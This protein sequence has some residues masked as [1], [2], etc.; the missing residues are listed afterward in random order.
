MTSLKIA[1]WNLDGLSPNKDHV[2]ILLHTHNID[3]LLVSETHF[4]ASSCVKIKNYQIYG[5]N[6]PD[7]TAHAGSAVIVRTNIRHSEQRQ[8]KKPHIQAATITVEDR[9]GTFNVTAVY[10][11]P[12]HKITQEQYDEL[13]H[14]L[15]PRFIVGGDWNAKNIHWGSRLTNTRGRALMKS[16]DKNKLTAISTPEPTNW[17]SDPNRLPDVIDFFIAK[18]LPRLYY[19]IETCLDANTNHVPVILTIG[20][21][22]VNITR[23]TR[24]YNRR[25]DWFSFQ[26]LVH[27]KLDLKTD[28]KSE[29]DIDKAAK[30]FTTTIQECCWHCTPAGTV[31]PP[32]CKVYSENIR[33][34][35]RDKRRLR[36]VWHTSR[37]P[38]DK[39]AFNKAVKELKILIREAN[40]IAL[41]T[42]LEGLT[43]TKETNYSLWRAC[44]NFD[45]PLHHKPPLRK[46]DGE[47]AR[48][49]QSKAE[50]FARHL[51]QVFK[52]NN[53]SPTADES[54]I[55]LVLNQDFQ[56]D[57][58]LKPVTP[59]EVRRN[60]KS[61][62]NNK[63]P[64]FDLI[65]KKIL[66]ELPRK[67]ITY[68]TM[69]FNAILRVGYFPDVWKASLVIMI[70]KPGKS[71]HEVTS[72]RPISLLPVLSKLF[73]KCLLHR[74]SNVINDK[75][76]IPDHQFGFRREHSTIEQ[77]HRVCRRIRKSFELKEY[78]SAAFLDIQQAFDK[79]WHRGLL[80]K[81]KSLLPH[82]FYSVL[83]SYI[84]DRIFQVREDDSTSQF[85]DISAGVPQGSV[86]GPVLYILFTSDLPQGS[87]VT[88]AT[89]AD[90]TAFL[91]SNKCPIEASRILQT[92]LH[93]IEKWLAKWRITASVNKSIHVTFTLRKEDCAPVFLNGT[94]LPH[95]ESVKYLGMHLD[96]R[97]TWQKHVKTKRNEIL[98]KVRGLHW[99]MGRNSKL[100]IDNKILIYKT[101][102]KP[103][104]TYGIQLWGAASASNQSTLQR[105]QNGILRQVS[106]APW[107]LKTTELHEILN[108]PTVKE[109][110]ASYG[111]KYKARLQNHQNQLA[112]QLTIPEMNRRLK[113]RRDIYD[114]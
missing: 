89:F 105:V 97:L 107:F 9:N 60:I 5:T 13:F 15:G 23:T 52:P 17:P 26:E 76:I 18:G 1:I 74:L 50:V 27:N 58:P 88:M 92:S 96:R 78:C 75:V 63:A 101:M 77:V 22:V 112:G 33:Q 111:D 37:H 16:L 82:T 31:L 86:L 45:R 34:Q 38:S 36:R 59:S 73:E 28:L 2:E 114:E 11:P 109:E 98:I 20:T 12:K 55:D 91:A 71:P 35:I 113:K 84:S 85:Y 57:L 10:C 41:Q 87:N 14:T 69:L 56:L 19:T 7:G 79:V 39:A 95:A 67:A 81:I 68:L 62:D 3:I 94:Q 21:T 8:F 32:K 83:K 103:I 104:W 108:I 30:T 66:E 100:S 25:T 44:K 61:M 48:S 90:D 46:Q 54:D 29:S 80:Y 65:D 106:N 53:A 99:L 72:Y 24:L 4:T 110:I 93:E 64:G 49:G 43:A 70:Q 51:N 102:I 42:Y 47:W 6:H 40:D